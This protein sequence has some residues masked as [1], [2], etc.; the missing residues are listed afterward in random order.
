MDAAYRERVRR[1]A[2]YVPEAVQERLAGLRV[3]VAGCG[4]GSALAEALLRLGVRR[5]R[6]V[7]GDVVEVHNLNRQD[8]TAAD[9]GRSKVEALRDRLLAI[10]PAAEVEAL[11][12]LVGPGN[13]DTLVAGCDLV[14][15]TIDFLS[16][17]GVV[18]LHDAARTAGLPVLSALNIG[19]GGGLV[20]FPPAGTC[21][22]RTLFGLPGQGSVDGYS[23]TACYAAL[24]RRIGNQLDLQVA[25]VMAGAL[26]VM[27]DGRPCPAPQVVA[28]SWAMAALVCT[29]LVRLLAGRL[30]PAAP[31]L[32]LLA[33][34]DCFA[35]GGIDLVAPGTG[36]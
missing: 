15:D 10:D 29:A 34:D 4:M 7:D 33:L 14:V 36:P 22:V 30:L 31:R 2:G 16:L 19:F 12:V 35:A 20:H 26:Q 32:V 18:A 8:F 21:T 3:L 13:A 24:V 6:L 1:N 11:P 27:A 23:Y 17:A 25:T 9:V 28:G 5:L